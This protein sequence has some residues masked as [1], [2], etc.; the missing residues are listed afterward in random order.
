MDFVHFANLSSPEGEGFQPS[1]TGTIKRGRFGALFFT[2]TR[3]F[4]D[5]LLSLSDNSGQGITLQNAQ[6]ATGPLQQESD[7][8]WAAIP[9]QRK[10]VP[11]S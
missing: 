1:L 5:F 9:K 6:E 8:R 11:K 10:K 7:G 4:F 3:D 2:E